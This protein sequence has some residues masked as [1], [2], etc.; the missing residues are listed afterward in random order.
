[1]AQQET[2]GNWLGPPAPPKR[3]TRQPGIYSSTGKMSPV[4]DFRPASPD[5]FEDD[6]DDVSL[7]ES[8]RE[9]R[10][11]PG[12]V[13]TLAGSPNP[14]R[15]GPSPSAGAAAA[16]PGKAEL[17]PEPQNWDRDR[18]QGRALCRG[19]SGVA[20]SVLLGLNLLGWALILTLGMEKH[21]EIWEELQLLKSNFSE[22][23]E[24]VLRELAAA[25]RR[26]TRLRGWI[27]QHFQE[28]EEVTALLCRSLEGSRRCSAGWQ[29][30]GKSCYSFSWESSSWG[31]AREACADLGSHLV[32][33]N[34]EDEQ[35]FLIE[36]MN[37]SSSYWLGITDREENG[38]WDWINGEKPSFS[39]WTILG[40][41]GDKDKD[42]KNCGIIDPKG[43][44]NND[45]C[46]NPHPWIC[47]KSWNC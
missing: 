31:E 46:S 42:L 39:F 44:W 4:G 19:R 1:M 17:E 5:S 36:N 12:T 20:L 9:P 7:A 24:S 27:Q 43:F 13:Y 21:R 8:E 34:D 28:L 47:E 32:V 23:Q 38:K 40:K 33:V 26:Q 37:R 22:N 25:Q 15:A 10:S 41:E 2:Y 6:Y 35:K 3:L 29:L 18:D 16:F 30:F 11:K 45:L 14:S